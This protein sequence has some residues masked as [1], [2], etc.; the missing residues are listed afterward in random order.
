M[1]IKRKIGVGAA[2]LIALG[3]STF[4]LPLI[5]R[6]AGASSTA[7]L[8]TATVVNAD[9][10]PNVQVGA[11]TG[12]DGISTESD[13][14]VSSETSASETATTSDTGAASDGI[15]GHADSAGNVANQSTTEQ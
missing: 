9:Q 12:V 1:N 5:S 13:V 6:A 4:G 3:G 7:A 15:G 8:S 2:G 10:G 11:Q 14:D